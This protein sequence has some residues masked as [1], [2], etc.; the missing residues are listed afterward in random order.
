MKRKQDLFV[1]HSPYISAKETGICVQRFIVYSLSQ[2]QLS[3][4]QT[5]SNC[6]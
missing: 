6:L 2:L 5:I 4:I 1:K 3:Q